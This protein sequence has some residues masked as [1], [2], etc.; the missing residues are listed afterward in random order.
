MYQRILFSNFK[1]CYFFQG[2]CLFTFQHEDKCIYVL[3]IKT[4]FFPSK[5]FLKIYVNK[6]TRRI[7][8]LGFLRK[9]GNKI[10]SQN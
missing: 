1:D 3:C 4:Y 5:F 9:Y 8:V 6:I 7:N 2:L 10:H